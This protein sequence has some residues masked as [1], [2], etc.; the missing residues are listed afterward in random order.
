MEQD[1]QEG[2]NNPKN[3]TYLFKKLTHTKGLNIIHIVV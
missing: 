3:R 1:Y 2:I